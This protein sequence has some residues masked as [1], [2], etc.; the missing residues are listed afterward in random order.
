MNAAPNE[1]ASRSTDP[2]DTTLEIACDEPW[3]LPPPVRQRPLSKEE[4]AQIKR[5]CHQSIPGPFVVGDA[6]DGEDRLVATLADGRPLVSRSLT[7]G[8]RL[9]PE[10]VEATLQ[11]FCR[12]RHLLLHLLA[13]RES[14]Q[15]RCDSLEQQCDQLADRVR[16]LS[17]QTDSSAGWRSADV[18]AAINADA[19][20]S[21][22]VAPRRPR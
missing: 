5:L 22:S 3:Q 9:E 1:L 13:E 6:A 16:E 8:E 15:R 10:A 20:P 11:L 18:Q 4:V 2:V 12:A 14:L 7:M 19:E 17:I 21:A